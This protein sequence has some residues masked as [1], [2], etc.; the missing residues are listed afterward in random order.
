MDADLAEVHD[1]SGQGEQRGEGAEPRLGRSFYAG[2]G[3]GQVAPPSG[4]R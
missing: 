3:A 2:Y 1:A 4:E